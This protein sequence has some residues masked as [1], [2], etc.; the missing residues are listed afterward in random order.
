MPGCRRA[1]ADPAPPTPPL[2]A[3]R[4][5]DPR[6]VR[7]RARGRRIGGTHPGGEVA[8]AIPRLPRGA[9][10][11]H[12]HRPALPRPVRTVF[13]ITFFPLLMSPFPPGHVLRTSPHRHRPSPWPLPHRPRR[14]HRAGHAVGVGIRRPRARVLAIRRPPQVEPTPYLTSSY[15]TIGPTSYLTPYLSHPYLNPYLTTGGTN[16][17]SSSNSTTTTCATS[18][19]RRS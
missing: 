4:A 8:P 16:A 1:P 3:R 7:P 19:C 2:H 5:P 17:T 14:R 15:L 10:D 18:S 6:A 12:T 11:K 13:G 9:S